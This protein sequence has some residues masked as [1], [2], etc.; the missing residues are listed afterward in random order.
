MFCQDF[1]PGARTAGAA[2]A[3]PGVGHCLRRRGKTAQ[4]LPICLVAPRR[5][6]VDMMLNPLENPSSKQVKPSNK[7][8]PPFLS[9][10]ISAF[11]H[12]QNTF[13]EL[14]FAEAQIPAAALGKEKELGAQQ[15]VLGRCARP[16]EVCASSLQVLKFSSSVN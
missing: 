10:L 4:V 7:K 5:I 14:H 8:T 13:P 11:L 9:K 1:S 16:F 12:V 15:K 2:E 6:I 3:A